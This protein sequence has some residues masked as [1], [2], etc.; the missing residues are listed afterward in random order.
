MEIASA[1]CR[2]NAPSIVKFGKSEEGL[3]HHEFGPEFIKGPQKNETQP[4]GTV[5]DDS[6]GHTNQQC[7]QAKETTMSLDHQW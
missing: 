2:K 1:S 5:E 3:N 6:E 4:L 7:E